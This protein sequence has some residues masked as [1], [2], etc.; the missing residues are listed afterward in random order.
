MDIPTNVNSFFRVFLLLNGNWDFTQLNSLCLASIAQRVAN[1]IPLSLSLD[2]DEPF[3]GL[4]PSGICIM[5]SAY[6]YLKQTTTTATDS[7]SGLWDL[8]WKWK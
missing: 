4:F 7:N 1:A 6:E 3:W 8:A 5:A 2:S